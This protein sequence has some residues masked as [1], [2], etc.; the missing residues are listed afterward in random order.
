MSL[1]AGDGQHPVQELLAS[2]GTYQ[3]DKAMTQLMPLA[4]NVPDSSIIS[5]YEKA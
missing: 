4:C 5:G 2:I 1:L 3:E